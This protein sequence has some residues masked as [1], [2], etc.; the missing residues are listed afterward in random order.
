MLQK[1][2]LVDER[3]RFIIMASLNMVFRYFIFVLLGVIFGT[4]HYQKIL[5]AMWLISSVIA[6][7]SYKTLVF[8]TQGNHLKEYGKSV[9]IWGFSYIINAVVLDVLVVKAAFN[10]YAAQAVVISFLLITN[11]LLFKHFAFKKPETIWSRWEKMLRFFDL[12][13]K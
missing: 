10:V 11:Y 1:W 3:V 12:F 9:L 5:L 2:F 6:F 7:Y 13:S 4:L 8:S